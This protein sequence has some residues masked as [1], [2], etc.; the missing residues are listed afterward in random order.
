MT[1]GPARRPAWQRLYLELKR[2]RK[3]FRSPLSSLGG[4]LGWVKRKLEYRYVVR[5]RIKTA[6]DGYKA[7]PVSKMKDSFVLVRI[8]GNDLEPRHRRGQSYDN[9]LFILDNECDFPDCEKVWIVNRIT[10][11]GEEARIIGLLE[12]RGQSFH[13]I[14]FDL[15]AY[16]QV[17]W[18]TDG[19]AANESRFSNAD[20]RP[21]GQNASRYET[22]IR[23]RKNLYVM[24]N[25]GARNTALEIA[26]GRAKWLMPWD[27]NCYL[28]PPAFQ[29]IRAA[30]EENPHFRYVVVPM[31]RIVDNALLLDETLTPPAQEEPQII[32]RNDTTELFDEE[33]GYGRRP[34]VEMLWR[35]GVPGLWDRFR[36]DAWDIP[37]PRLAADAGLF[38]KAGWVARLDSGRSHLEIGRAGFRARLF[39]R[40]EAIVGMLDRCDATAV[41][42]KLDPARLAYYDEDMLVAARRE[43]NVHAQQ[44]LRACAEQALLRGP[45]SVMDKTARAPSGDPHDYF[46]PAPYWW[47][48]PRKPDGLPFIRR[49]G[50]HA[51]GTALYD[52]AGEAYDRTRL[53]RVLDDTTVLALATTVLEDMRYASHAALLIRTWFVDPATRMNPNMRYAQVRYGRDNNE[54]PGYGIIELTDLYFFLDAVRLIERSG[55]LDERDSQAFRAWLSS[56]CEWLD[57]APA[58]RFEFHRL[59]NHGVFFD[60]Q[61]A[62]IAAFQG[63]GGALAKAGLHA[64]ERIAHQLAADGSLPEELSR[65]RPRHYAMFA[66]QGWTA[67]ARILSSVGDD[68]WAYRTKDGQGLVKALRWVAAHADTLAT[69]PGEA[70]DPERDRPL[71]DDLARHNVEEAAPPDA[72]AEATKLI[73]HPDC[74]IA[75]FWIWRRP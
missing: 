66:L 39:K 20:N 57:T 54:G 60:L 42:G 43:Q 31:A 1:A 47:P 74:A 19:L 29:Q 63:D 40:D 72:H 23:R 16:R 75:P 36:D 51:P 14:P 58:A 48:D 30:I 55:A 44:E 70:F 8:I 73:F 61:R 25:N 37:R 45:F 12:S 41:A 46:Q 22:H 34:K 27:G 35:L 52:A 13:R 26:R 28:T 21:G 49:D 33:Y 4:A 11:P 50:E 65:T 64:R 62:A 71:L 59:N 5:H 38:Q 32:F 15:D 2:A 53:Q 56:Y 6:R 17:A 69:L 3:H 9:A 7:L 67:L 18:N 10:D 24:N 68:L